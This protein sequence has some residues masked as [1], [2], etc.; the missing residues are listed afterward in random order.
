MLEELASKPIQVYQKEEKPIAEDLIS[1]YLAGL[2][3]W[4]I[5]EREGI[6]RL[7]CSFQFKDFQSA[8]DFTNRIGAIA[9]ETDHHPA[10]LVS[11]GRAAVSWWTHFVKGLHQNDFIMAART[12]LIFQSEFSL[13]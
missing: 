13:E 4:G 9:E 2:P 3:N 6:P 8:L 5:I 11:W 1:D 12:E 10:I 7:E